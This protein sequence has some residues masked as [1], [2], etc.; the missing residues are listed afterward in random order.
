[1][2]TLTTTLAIVLMIANVVSAQLPRTVKICKSGVVAQLSTGKTGSGHGTL[3]TSTFG[4]RCG[5]NII[6]IGSIL[7]NDYKRATG[8]TASY[9][10]VVK[11]ISRVDLYFNV[12]ANHLN[13]AHLSKDL[14]LSLHNEDFLKDAEKGRKEF[15]KFNTTEAYVGFGVLANVSR[16]VAINAGIGG[17]GH[18]SQITNTDYR[19][20]ISLARLDKAA[21]LMFNIGLTINTDLKLGL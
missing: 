3:S 8:V 9:Q 10:R 6:S 20:A 16:H 11:G 7:Q 5:N 1:M 13:N 18:F 12:T 19:R 21:G 4:Y 2:K 17:G 14:N 15:E